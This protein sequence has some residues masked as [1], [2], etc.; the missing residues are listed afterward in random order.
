ML[1][2]YDYCRENDLKGIL[3]RWDG[4]RN[5]PRRPQNIAWDSKRSV[6]WKC[7]HGHQWGSSP[8]TTIRKA[9][10][11]PTCAGI[12]LDPGVND[13]A[14][15]HPELLEQWDADKN[16]PLRPE[17]I[18]SRSIV[19]VWW[20]CRQG[21]TW[22]AVIRDRV[23]GEGCPHCSG[24][25]GRRQ[26]KPFPEAYPEL[27]AEWD[28]ERNAGRSPWR[29]KDLAMARVHWICAQGHRWQATMYQ[30]T[31]EKAGCPECARLATMEN[32]LSE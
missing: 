9:G 14:S 29:I 30:R 20:K 12:R 2:L 3:T 7:E 32:M 31:K 27:Y 1:S 17:K 8:K 21:H 18:R 24:L 19:I 23:E 26:K 6:Y 16:L 28:M 13:L 22:K 5:L 4:R 25:I 10:R 11:C 15:M